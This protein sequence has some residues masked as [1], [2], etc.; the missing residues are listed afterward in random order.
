MHRWLVT[1]LSVLFLSPLAGADTSSLFFEST[2]ESQLENQGYGA[3]ELSD[4]GS[5]AY[6]T[7][8]NMLVEFSTNNQTTIQSKVFDQEILSIALSPDGLRLALTLRDGGTGE[9]T[10]YVLDSDTFNTR[11][12]SQT[13]A[14]NAVLLSWTD[15]GASL[16]TNHPIAGLTKMNREDLG[17]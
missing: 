5:R 8:G 17:I 7:F 15:N 10:I 1:A 12:S 11:I 14:S 2:Y 13:T 4:D 9:D 6:A 3:I 16:L